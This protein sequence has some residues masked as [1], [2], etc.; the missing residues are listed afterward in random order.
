MCCAHGHTRKY[1]SYVNAFGK[2]VYFYDNIVHRAALNRTESIVCVRYGVRWCVM[3][4]YIASNELTPISGKSDIRTTSATHHARARLTCSLMA[5]YICC[6]QCPPPFISPYIFGY[7]L[8]CNKNKI[9]IWISQ[10]SPYFQQLKQ[11]NAS[12]EPNTHF[13]FFPQCI[14]MHFPVTIF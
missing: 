7:S 2:W 11:K 12:D 5:Y 8:Q 14:L 6:G 9:S 3:F 1:I 4:A 10:I 13:L